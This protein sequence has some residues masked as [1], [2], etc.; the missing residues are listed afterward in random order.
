MPSLNEQ[1]TPSSAS[2]RAQSQ[3]R[4]EQA[5]ICFFKKQNYKVTATVGQR[6][7]LMRA[8]TPVLDSGAGP[9]L[10]HLRCAAEPWRAA[11]KSARSLLLIDASN[12]SM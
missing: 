6:R 11:I 10:I 12:W 1:G 7:A 4:T 8:I 2:V 9:N 5:A 3:R